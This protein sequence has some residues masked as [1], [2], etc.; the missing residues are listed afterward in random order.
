MQV[1]PS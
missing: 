1:K